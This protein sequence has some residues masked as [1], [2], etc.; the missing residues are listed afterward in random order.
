MTG[1]LTI[2]RIPRRAPRA[3]DA[4]GTE[5]RANIEVR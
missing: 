1:L 5:L 4:A 3:G 2:R